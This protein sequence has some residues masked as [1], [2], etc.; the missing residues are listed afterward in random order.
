MALMQ[1]DAELGDQRIREGN[2]RQRPAGQGKLANG[3]D[4]PGGHGHAVRAVLE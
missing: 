1:I 2:L 3:D 4:T